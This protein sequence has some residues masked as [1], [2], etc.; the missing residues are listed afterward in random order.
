MSK[1]YTAVIRKDGSVEVTG[2]SLK[3]LKA[4]ATGKGKV[5]GDEG[6]VPGPEDW[7]PADEANKALVEKLQASGHIIET[8]KEDR[9]KHSELAALLMIQQNYPLAVSSGKGKAA[10]KYLKVAFGIPEGVISAAPRKM[11]RKGLCKK[12]AHKG[13]SFK[14]APKGSKLLSKYQRSGQ[15]KEL[16]VAF[17]EAYPKRI[18]EAVEA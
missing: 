11:V 16:I 10:R 15:Y 13:E 17:K 12:G 4:L 14:L 18:E 5:S 3:D 1:A 9:T 8:S 7:E 2:L 6:D